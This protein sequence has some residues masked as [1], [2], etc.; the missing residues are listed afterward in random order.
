MIARRAFKTVGVAIALL[1]L[2]G[3][4][5]PYITADQFGSRLQGSLQR[6][7]GRR[8]DLR[9]KVR[10]SLLHG[11]A[12]RVDPG[13]GS[14]GVVIHEDPSLGVEP[15]AYVGALE[16]R[17]SLWHLLFGKFVIASIRLEDA[18]I[19]LTKS[20]PASEW[21]RWN[22]ASI[23]NPAVMH[24]LPAIHVRNGRI[25]FKFGDDKS[26]FYLTET[27]FDISP[28]G[29]IGRGGTFPLRPSWRVPT[30]PLSALALSPSKGAG[31]SRRNESI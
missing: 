21:G 8:V 9:A 31:T 3:V 15:V 19:N 10:F 4:V 11:P 5:A 23:V 18:S 27:D 28:P 29:A 2:L 20:G 25:N 12:F 6:A 16:V 14:S 30:G 7:L 24:E 22:F 1:L 17:P 26:G 13:D